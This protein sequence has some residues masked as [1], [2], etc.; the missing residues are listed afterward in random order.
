MKKLLVLLALLPTLLLAQQTDSWVRF[1]VQFDFYAPSES[2]FFM[3]EDTI[4][5]DTAN[6]G[7]SSTG[8]NLQPYIVVYMWKR[9]L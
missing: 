5:G 3:V 4:S 1:A 2:N 9:T 8:K 7:E 6:A